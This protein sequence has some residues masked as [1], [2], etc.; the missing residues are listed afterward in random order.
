[1]LGQKSNYDNSRMRNALR[2]EPQPIDKT[3]IDMANSM[4]EKNYIKKP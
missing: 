4:I 3:L 1:M 2:I